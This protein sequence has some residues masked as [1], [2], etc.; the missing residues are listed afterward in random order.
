MQSGN[1]MGIVEGCNRLSE[2]EWAWLAN[3]FMNEKDI[4]IKL[5]SS[6]QVSFLVKSISD[7]QLVKLMQE[8]SNRLLSESIS[9]SGR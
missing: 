7:Q 4:S 9:I 8:V 5:I 1:L 2:D 6:L 3:Y